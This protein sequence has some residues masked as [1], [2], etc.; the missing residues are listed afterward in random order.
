MSAHLT[1]VLQA[2]FVVFLWATSWVLIK[3]G[4][5]TLPPITFAGLRYFLAF[6]CLLGVVIRNEVKGEITHL[7]KQD[8]SRLLVLGLLFYAGTQG[9]S[10]VALAYL[11]A[12]TVNLLWSFSSVTVALMGSIWLAEKPTFLQWSGIILSIVGA[13]VY[14]YPV[15]LPHAQIIGI[16]VALV[17]ILANAVSSILGRGINR[18]GKFQPLTVTVVSMGAGSI[19]LLAFGWYVDGIPVIDL[20]GWTIIVWLAVV[21][22][23]FAFTLWNHT[24]R[25]LTAIES[26]VANG[27]M[28]IWIP[29][30]A[31]LFLGES[32]TRM[33][34]AGLAVVGMGTL[35]VQ[36]RRIPKFPHKCSGQ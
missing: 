18:S 6:V 36:L 30:F 31:I 23:A 14:F 28:M 9:A 8:W 35:I 5:Q 19:L 12:I 34:L 17:G 25:T 24:L 27:T 26:S 10:F 32:I 29:I 11:P 1:A 22:T 13:W 16:I 7:S 21:N 2:L 15:V 4:L 3:I 20:K 33:E